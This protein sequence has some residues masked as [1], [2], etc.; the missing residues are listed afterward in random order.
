[1]RLWLFVIAAFA[2]LCCLTVLSARTSSESP[3]LRLTDAN[4]VASGD[5]TTWFSAV[6]GNNPGAVVVGE[7]GPAGPVNVF[8]LSSADQGVPTA[9]NVDAH[10][11]FWFQGN[12]G[13]YIG[14]IS[15]AG[16][17]KKYVLSQVS[18]GDVNAAPNGS[19][20]FTDQQAGGVGLLDARG[21]SFRWILKGTRVHKTAVA[22][23]SSLWFTGVDTDT[24]NHLLS[25]GNNT[26]YKV[27]AEGDRPFEPSEIAVAKDGAV[28][29]SAQ[30]FLN[31]VGTITPSGSLR[32][33]WIRPSDFGAFALAPY[34][35]SGV[36][37]AQ[38][39]PSRV[40]TIDAA[41]HAQALDVP[42]KGREVE[43]TSIATDRLGDVWLC[44]SSSK[45]VGFWRLDT[46]RHFTE[47]TSV[48]SAKQ[49][50]IITIV[51]RE[52]R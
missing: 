27:R 25:S 42:I 16:I 24:V 1:M 36:W 34:D 19:V 49:P 6:I 2:C 20:W 52:V 29:F 50:Q 13:R 47:F 11:V 46:R 43:P 10:G 8:A 4:V 26:Q 45:G 40:G 41:G 15:S 33:F 12:G 31:K 9:G 37:F 32:T 39:R 22:A 35:G 21:A 51:V 18:V 44:D 28:W 3:L 17:L 7:L 5:G 38:S 30:E 23:D 48:P 14:E